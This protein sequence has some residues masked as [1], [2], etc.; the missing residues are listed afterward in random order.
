MK[1]LMLINFNL[2]L[3]LAEVAQP[4]LQIPQMKVSMLICFNHDFAVVG[5]AQATSIFIN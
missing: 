1:V 2:Y 5:A 4:F 3:V